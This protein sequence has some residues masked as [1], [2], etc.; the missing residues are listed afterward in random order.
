MRM[1]VWYCAMSTTSM[2]AHLRAGRGEEA[3]RSEDAS[4]LL[5]VDGAG[6]ITVH[7]CK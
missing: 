6:L 1:R 3:H 4:E 2:C 7:L 5:P